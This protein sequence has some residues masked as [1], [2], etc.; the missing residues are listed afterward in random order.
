MEKQETKKTAIAV[1]LSLLVCPGAGH[2]YLKDKKM[3]YAFMLTITV[4]LFIM[5]YVIEKELLHQA[6]GISDPTVLLTSVS[7]LAKKAIQ[8]HGT[9]LRVGTFLVIMLW[10]AAP[11]D[12]ILQLRSKKY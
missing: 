7:L 11:V 6:Q 8:A 1:L 2:L 3:G 4:I 9:L 5:I 12:L 10:I